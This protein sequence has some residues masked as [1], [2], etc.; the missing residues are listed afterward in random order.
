MSRMLTFIPI[1][2]LSACQTME[3][4][5]EVLIV[6][7]S[8]SGGQALFRGSIE[9]RA[10]CLVAVSGDRI[11]TVLFDPGVRLASD[12]GIIEANTDRAIKFGAKLEGASAILRE[13][14][15]G[16]QLTDLEQ[17]FGVT[18]PKTCPSDNVMRLRDMVILEE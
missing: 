15:S 2:L 16:W 9:A 5:T 18:I 17:Y 3:P 6:T 1:A 4:R 8:T 10:G 11:A 13:N 14:G 12:E 7:R